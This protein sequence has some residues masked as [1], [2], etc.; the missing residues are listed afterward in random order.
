MEDYFIGNKWEIF[1][2]RAI[3]IVNIITVFPEFLSISKYFFELR[4]DSFF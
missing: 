1:V 3:Y 2:L 4:K